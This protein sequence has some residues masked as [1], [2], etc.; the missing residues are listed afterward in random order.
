MAAK[1]AN[2]MAPPRDA[3]REFYRRIEA[4]VQADRHQRRRGR[5]R[6]TSGRSTNLHRQQLVEVEGQSDILV[7]GH[8][9]T[10]CPYNVNSILNP[11][12]VHVPGARLPVQHVPQQAARARRAAS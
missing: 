6:S 8:A 3:R 7:V 11:I 5:G 12:L 1:K 9:R 2:D 10:S 4:P